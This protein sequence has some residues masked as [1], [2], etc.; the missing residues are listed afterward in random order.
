MIIIAGTIDVDPEQREA[1]MTAV[2]PIQK[3]TRDDEP[4]CHA[5][6]FAPD[7]VV[8]GRIQV[9]ELWDTQVSLAAHFTHPNYLNM[10]TTLGQFGIRRADNKKY[11]VDHCE[12]VYDETRTPRAD[13]FTV[14]PPQNVL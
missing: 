10:R 7:P 13:F 11:R 14:E 2:A 5:Y 12:P 9:Y 8:D 6:C 3:A 4:G 1:C